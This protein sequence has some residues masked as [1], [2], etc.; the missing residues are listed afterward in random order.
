MSFRPG[1][2]VVRLPANAR[3]LFLPTETSESYE[4]GFKSEF[5]DDMVKVDVAAYQQDFKN[6]PFR[7]AS[8]VPTV[9]FNTAAGLPRVAN[10]N[11]VAPV[12]LRVKG[13]EAEVDGG[14]ATAST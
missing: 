10:V 12:P 5:F 4:I 2:N 3:F 9:Q 1:N 7:S 8:G 11:F 14:R 6:Y 13:F